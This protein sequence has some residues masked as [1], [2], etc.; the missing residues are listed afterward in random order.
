VEGCDGAAGAD[1]A[2][3]KDFH[4]TAIAGSLLGAC[5]MRKKLVAGQGKKAIGV[6]PYAIAAQ[7]AW[8]LATG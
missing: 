3:R 6:I 7:M 4:G 1:L 8:I 2:L 5:L